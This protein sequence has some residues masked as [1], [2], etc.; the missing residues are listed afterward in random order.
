MFDTLKPRANQSKLENSIKLSIHSRIRAIVHVC[1]QS[2]VPRQ[3]SDTKLGQSDFISLYS[4][5]ELWSTLLEC[6]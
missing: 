2:T 1:T 4:N 3:V 6:H 5:P